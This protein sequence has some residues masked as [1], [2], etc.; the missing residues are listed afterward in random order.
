[1]LVA[2]AFV[3]LFAWLGTLHTPARQYSLDAYAQHYVDQGLKRALLTFAT[4]RSLE[5]IMSVAQATAIAFEPAGVG[6]QVGPGQLIRPLNDL[7]GQFAELT[8]IASIVFGVMDILLRIGSHWVVSLALSFAA[9]NWATYRWRAIQPPAWLAKAL[10]VLLL[11]RFAVPVVSLG[12][13]AVYAA[14]MAE[15][16]VENQGAIQTTSKQLEDS[17]SA[18]NDSPAKKDTLAEAKSG[19]IWDWMRFKI[20]GR[21][22]AESMPEPGVLQ[23]IEEWAAQKVDV[24][25]RL[26]NLVQA[27]EALTERIVRLMVVFVLQTLVIPLLLAWALV[28][29]AGAFFQVRAR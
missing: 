28:R 2:V 8:L 18:K 20:G 29:G 17:V 1:M 19:G 4:A 27:G 16:Y 22:D 13:E 3:A 11:I 15:S 14:F 23:R 5:G 7:V 24:G 6:V 9:V 21:R 26:K 12:N 25:A 10:L